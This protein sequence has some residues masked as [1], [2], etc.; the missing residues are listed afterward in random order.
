MTRNSPKY[1]RIVNQILSEIRRGSYGV[2]DMLP[3]EHRLMNAFG[4]SRHTV[5]QAMQSLK[6]MGIIQAH[7]G[8]GSIVVSESNNAAFIEKI[9]SLEAIVDMGAEL[10]RRLL[11]KT[12][13]VADDE[14]AGAF[15]CGKGREFLEM[16]FVRNLIQEPEVPTVFLKVW[17]DPI[18][19]SISDYL[20]TDGGTTRD[21]IVE[22]MKQHFEFDTGAI[23][24]TVSACAIDAETEAV[25]KLPVGECALK[26]ERRYYQNPVSLPHLR[27]IS[28]CRGDLLRIESHFQAN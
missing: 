1:N 22:V 27:S 20:E 2:G 14:L 7:Q 19:E 13:V 6:Q 11:K 28:I 10:N 16:H 4:V 8:K 21:A 18:F 25:L 26:I 9:P 12:V 3:T 23:R 17:I 15:G 5:R 24:Q